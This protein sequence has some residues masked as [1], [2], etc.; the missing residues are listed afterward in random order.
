M[1]LF[2]ITVNE[3]EWCYDCYDRKLVRALD[4]SS[5][6]SIASMV[7]GDEGCSAWLDNRYSTAEVV[8][9]NGESGVIVDSFNAG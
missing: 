1:K 4:E 9:V 7:H 3:T 8:T 5:A 2:L 6:R